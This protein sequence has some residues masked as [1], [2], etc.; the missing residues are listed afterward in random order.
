MATSITGSLRPSQSANGAP[1]GASSGRS[2]MP[3][4]SS[5][6]PI[7]RS[8][9]SM[10]FDSWPRITPFFRSSPVPG[11][12]VPAAANTPFM[13]VRALGAPHTTWIRSSP[14]STMQTLSR[15]ASGCC[16]ASTTRAIRKGASSAALSSTLSTSRPMAVSFAA[17]SSSG[18]SVSRCSLSQDRVNF[19]S[20][21]PW[22]WGRDYLA[23]RSNPAT[24]GRAAPPKSS[25]MRR[26]P[27]KDSKRSV[28]LQ[29]RNHP[30]SVRFCRRSAWYPRPDRG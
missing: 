11:I 23:I 10:P 30:V 3:S 19:M 7:S 13:P 28:T 12:C 20:G 26:T 6:R 29:L 8:E 22:R 17:I 15:S 16:R 2:M 27:G 21:V 4:C 1:T 18:A 24:G 14:V 25:A 9:H 5:D